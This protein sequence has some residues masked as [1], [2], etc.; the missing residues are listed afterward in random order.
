MSRNC[1]PSRSHRS[2][3]PQRHSAAQHRQF[4]VN[5][6]VIDREVWAEQT[7]ANPHLSKNP[8]P[9]THYGSWAEQVRIGQLTPSGEDLWWYLKC[10]DE[11]DAL[12]EKVVS[13]LLDLAVPWL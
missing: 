1:S 6:S 5:L 13:A 9:S 7:S 11:P 12:A 4:T 8:T 10:G 3:R 2:A